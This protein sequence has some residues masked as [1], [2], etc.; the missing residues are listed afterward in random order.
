[1]KSGGGLRRI[2]DDFRRVKN[3]IE[4]R[5]VDNRWVNPLEAL[6]DQVPAAIPEN[7]SFTPDPDLVLKAEVNGE[8]WDG[9][10]RQAKV[11]MKKYNDG[12]KSTIDADKEISGCLFSSFRVFT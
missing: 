11:E 8:E 10:V 4:A 6:A 2:K 7:M 5:V 12:L 3:R 9:L 1:V